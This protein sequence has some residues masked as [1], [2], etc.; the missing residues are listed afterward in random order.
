MTQ[1]E[2]HIMALKGMYI[3]L[4][5]TQNQV[6]QL[7]AERDFLIAENQQL[8]ESLEDLK[9]E[10]ENLGYEIKEM[11]NFSDLDH[12]MTGDAHES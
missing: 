9:Q 5:E 6:S 7:Q 12:G 11:G 4:G 2:V 1:D 3:T 10:N 8:K